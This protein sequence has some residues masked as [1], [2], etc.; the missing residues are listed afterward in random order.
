MTLLSL[1]LL[2]EETTQDDTLEDDIGCL[3]KA[4]RDGYLYKVTSH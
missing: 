1:Q 2:E 3:V 4:I